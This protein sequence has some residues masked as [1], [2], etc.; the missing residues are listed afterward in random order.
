[1]FQRNVIIII[2]IFIV[3]RD[4]SKLHKLD[5]FL[6]IRE[7]NEDDNCSHGS[8]D[9]YSES[10]HTISFHDSPRNNNE[11]SSFHNF[12][13]SQHKHNINVQAAFIHIIGDIIQSI[14]VIIAASLIY[15]FP[16]YQIIDPFTTIL[17]S[18]IVITTTIPIIKQCIY[19]IMEGNTNAE[20]FTMIKNELINTQGVI[21][22]GCLH[23]YYLSLDKAILCAHLKVI[24]TINECELLKRIYEELSKYKIYHCTIEISKDDNNTCNNNME[25]G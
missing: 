17:F 3:T 12:S 21:S 9:H 8:H 1:M 25:I 10:F 15:F 18:I 16:S 5:A 19:A 2:I 23:L 22:V 4:H 7:I 13:H 24:P 20:D 11:Q 14:G 6:G